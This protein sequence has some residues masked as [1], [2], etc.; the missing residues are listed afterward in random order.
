MKLRQQGI[1]STTV[2]RRTSLPA[3]S[4]PGRVL[5]G[6]AQRA[7]PGGE[8][9]PAGAHGFTLVEVMVVMLIMSGLLVS[10][11]QVLNA[12]RSTRDV[13]YNVQETQLSGPAILDLIERDLRGMFLFTRYSGDALLVRDR[14]NAGFDADSIHFVTSNNALL[15][16]ESGDEFVRSDVCEVG[17]ALRPNPDAP[18]DFLEIWRRE[19]YGIDELPF[20]GGRFSFLHDRVKGFD[21]QLFEGIGDSAEPLD[22]WEEG[23]HEAPLPRRIEITLTLELAP[24]LVGEQLKVAPTDKR[25]L[26]YKRV[27]AMPSPLLV[28]VEVQPVPRPPEINPPVPGQAP[29]AAGGGAGGIPGPGGNQ[30]GPGMNP[31]G[32]GA[33]FGDLGG[34]QG[35]TP[36]LPGSVTELVGPFGGG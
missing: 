18:N 32:P 26:E 16:T 23:T 11:S 9:P 34:N 25:T 31:G 20:E 35:G 3:P 21:I 10:I 28:A 4:A 6:Q 15:R 14:V 2:D 8:A 19:S 22:A 1:V 12:A 29:G 13:I 30:G 27:I 24:R 7:R 33:G 36:T 5:A 17:Y